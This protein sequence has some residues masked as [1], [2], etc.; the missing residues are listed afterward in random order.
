MAGD[1][2]SSI[3]PRLQYASSLPPRTHSQPSQPY[4]TA[5]YLPTSQPPPP[6]PQVAPQSHFDPALGQTSPAQDSHDDDEHD[7]GDHDGSP[8]NAK[9]P[10]DP[11]RPRAC[12]SCRGL[13]VG[14]YTHGTGRVVLTAAGPLRPGTAG[15]ALQA[16]RKGEPQMVSAVPDVRMHELTEAALP[17]PPQESDRRRPTVASPSWNARLTP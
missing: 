11:K 15:P 7:E 14:V 4:A 13:K 3:D 8:G 17:H 1:A 6:P 16:V 10:S 9:S 12:D 2:D 5:Y